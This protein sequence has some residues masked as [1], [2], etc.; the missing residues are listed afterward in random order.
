MLIVPAQHYGPE[1]S[2]DVRAGQQTLFFP[3]PTREISARKAPTKQKRALL[4]CSRRA[5]TT[6]PG[7]RPPPTTTITSTTI[8]TTLSGR[9]EAMTVRKRISI[10]EASVR[11]SGHNE[12]ALEKP[13]F[14]RRIVF[15]VWGSYLSTLLSFS[16]VRRRRLVFVPCSRF[17]HGEIRVCYVTTTANNY[18]NTIHPQSKR[19]PNA[20]TEHPSSMHRP[21]L[22]FHL[23]ST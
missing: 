17:R 18:P 12:A 4:D 5:S 7:R 20:I 9:S 15:K 16:I 1:H 10:R 23:A 21:C 14:E 2:P 11:E 6:I 22:V 19:K 8:S 3:R 13:T